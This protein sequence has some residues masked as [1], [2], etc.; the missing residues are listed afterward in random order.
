M[1]V[2]YCQEDLINNKIIYMNIRISENFHQHWLALIKIN[3][4]MKTYVIKFDSIF[5][6]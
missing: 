2:I 3:F 1:N 5:G 4:I 6:G